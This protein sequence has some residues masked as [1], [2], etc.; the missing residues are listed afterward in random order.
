[1]DYLM[2]GSAP[3]T[4]EQWTT[5]DSAVVETARSQLVGRR[6]IPLAGPFGAGLQ[7]LPDDRLAGGEGHVD[8]LGQSDGAVQIERRRVVPLPLIY[9]DFWL[10]WRDLEAADQFHLP[11]DTS[12][13]SAATVVCAHAE[14]SL[15]FNGDAE[16]GEPG[17]LTVNE[18]LHAPLRDWDTPGEGFLAIVDGIRAL[19]DAE[20][21]GPYALVTSPRLYARLNRIFEGTGVLELEQIEK[22]VRAGVYQAAVMPETAVLVAAGAQNLDLAVSFDFTTAFVESTN[23]NYRFRVLESVVLRIK[24]P[25][26]ILTFDA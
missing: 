2:R 15:I 9:K 13:A 1:M 14:D 6:F 11:I 8:L 20:F 22:L 21:Y 26:A 19:T 16:F 23:L 4:A 10:F 3:L 17:L 5:L 25:Q 12:K 18:R 24:R 7:A